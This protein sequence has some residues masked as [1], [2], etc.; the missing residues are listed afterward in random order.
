MKN[1]KL[2]MAIH[3]SDLSQRDLA[4]SIGIHESV[5][6]MVVRGK[7]NLEYEQQVKIAN[8]LRKPVEHL[9]GE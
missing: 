9:F 2:I 4:R 1:L 3:E 7:Y 5:I 8:C 6:S